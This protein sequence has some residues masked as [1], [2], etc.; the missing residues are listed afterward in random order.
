V[1]EASA[2]RR[3]MDTFGWTQRCTAERLGLSR[4]AVSN[5]LRLL[6]LP[7]EAREQVGR[8]TLSERQALALLPVLELP[9]PA[10]ERIR[11][12]WCRGRVQAIVEDPQAH[13]STTIRRMVDD[14][15]HYVTADLA[16]AVFAPDEP[17][18]EGR[19]GVRSARCG[20]CEFRVR[21]GKGVLCGDVQCHDVKERVWC[22]DYLARASEA[23]G[24]L[25]LTM[26]EQDTL[27]YSNYDCLHPDLDG[28]AELRHAMDGQCPNLRIGYY[29]NRYILRPDGYDLAGYVCVH[30]GKRDCAC[31][32][33]VNRQTHAGEIA[34]E[35]ERKRHLAQ[36]KKQAVAQVSAALAEG[37]TGALKAVLVGLS[38]G[39][40]RKKA[41]T[42]KDHRTVVQRIACILVEGAARA[43]DPDQAKA[44]IEAW[45]ERL[46]IDG[47]TP[48][49]LAEVRRRWMR[50]DVWMGK[51][52]GERPA[53]EAVRG[54]LA[55][56]LRLAESLDEVEDED[57]RTDETESQRA[58]IARAMETLSSIRPVVETWDGNGFDDIGWLVGV[59]AG[60]VNFRA[61]LEQATPSVLRYALALSQGPACRQTGREGNKTR[62]KAL[63][64]RL[65]QLEGKTR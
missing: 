43:R 17:V 30:I 22:D 9:E 60:D 42:I 52:T 33:E 58:Q 53:P 6:R 24:V 55:N 3:M 47:A 39:S 41:A 23:L 61:H 21:R 51:L 12:S 35:K 8:G 40:S 25:A 19:E 38:S 18:A 44:E 64:R 48:D 31:Q 62:V 28:Q 65:R 11:E 14:V 34:A 59:P 7:D 29:P 20:E 4:P 54:N 27:S 26:V 10:Q 50:I 5:K 57:G 45:M 37:Q 63:E 16:E 56:L 13:S 32:N 49:P 36:I 46:G 1:E 2:I 15:L